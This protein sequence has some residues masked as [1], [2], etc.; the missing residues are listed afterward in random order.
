VSAQNHP[1]GNENDVNGDK[2]EGEVNPRVESELQ[3]WL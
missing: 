1:Q 3:Y 2:E